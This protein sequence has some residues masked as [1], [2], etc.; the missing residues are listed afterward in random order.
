MSKKMQENR[1][2]L[3]AL[4]TLFGTAIG[5]GIFGLPYVA[6]VVGFFPV[7][8]LMLVLGVLMLYSNLMYGEIVQRTKR[9]CGIVG[10][11]EKYLGPNGRRA[12]TVISFCSLYASNLIYIILGG[13]FLHSFFSGIFGGDEFFYGT[14]T[15]VL[16]ALA[17]YFNFKLFS[18]CESWMVVLLILL[19]GAT[20]F[21]CLPSI[22]MSNYFTG[23]LSQFFLPFGAILFALSANVAIPNM[24]HILEKKR[25]ALRS[26]IGWGTAA[27]V[28]CNALFIFA[29]LGV[30]GERTSPEAFVGLGQVIGDGVITLGFLIGFLAI[31]TS[32]L[33]SS[34]SA[35]EILWYDYRLGEKQAWFLAS[36]IPYL[37][38][39]SGMRDFIRIINIAGGITGGL[40][41]ILV[42]AIFYAA[43]RKGDRPSA[44]SLEIS[45]GFS[46]LMVL[47]FLL[48]IVYQFI[49]GF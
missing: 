34:E 9:R 46:A 16:A 8:G 12:A 45:A 21:R 1:E 18:V 41:G 27:Y 39:L 19:L 24:D 10:Y 37:I 31:I 11:A 38:Y 32:F 25:A 23:D 47:V 22:Q 13:I 40:F 5:A 30:T 6:S 33:V 36:F 29:V 2:Y 28:A 20:I 44:Y 48:G 43:K 17:T 49:Y 3:A 42:I 4:A 35:K 14:L 15:F 26:A 7:M